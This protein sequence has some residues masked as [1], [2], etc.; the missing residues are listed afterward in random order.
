MLYSFATG[1]AIGVVSLKELLEYL[2]RDMQALKVLMDEKVDSRNVV[3]FN[4]LNLQ[5]IKS[6][7]LHLYMIF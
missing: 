5:R 4:K 1:S 2:S 7:M 3:D 6:T